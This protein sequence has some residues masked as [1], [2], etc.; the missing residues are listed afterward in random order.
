VPGLKV[1]APYSGSDAK[2]LLK[3]PIRDP[4]PV[5]FLENEILYGRSFEVPK[6]DDFV[7]PIGKARIRAPRQGRDHRLL[8][9]RHDLCAR[10]AEALA[11]EGIDAEVI[12]LRT[13]RPM[14][15]ETVIASVQ[16]DQSLRRGRGGLPAVRRHRRDR[17]EDHG[18][19]LRLSRCAA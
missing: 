14:D 16:E 3:A 6:V 10:G 11:K 1:V 2:G 15:I 12:D 8:R 4:N 7:L 18:S 17:H 13:L 5:I 9:H 19:G